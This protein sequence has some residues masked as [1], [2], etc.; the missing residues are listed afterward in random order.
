MKE[1]NSTSIFGFFGNNRTAIV[2]LTRTLFAITD[3]FDVEYR[4][5]GRRGGVRPSAAAWP[6]P[7]NVSYGLAAVS[8]ARDLSRDDTPTGHTTALFGCQCV[9][10]VQNGMQL[11]CAIVPYE[12]FDGVTQS[13][14]ITNITWEVSNSPKRMT[15][16]STKVSVQSI[17]Y[18]A[19]RLTTPNEFN[20]RQTIRNPIACMTRSGCTSIDAVIWIMPICPI[21]TAPGSPPG[22][23]TACMS[24]LRDFSC[25]PFCLGVRRSFSANER[26]VVR[27]SNTWEDNVLLTARD[28]VLEV[29]FFALFLLSLVICLLTW[30]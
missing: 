12:T 19:Q 30:S 3:G 5:H 29:R 15:C 7:I 27:S 20:F 23:N 14:F 13:A 10:D 26:I 18:P 28:C 16:R 24:A 17:R 4:H 2:P 22:K 1:F 9:D 21:Y 6:I 25:F 11:I 8:Y